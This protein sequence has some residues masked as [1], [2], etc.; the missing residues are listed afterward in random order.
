MLFEGRL[1][2]C[3]WVMKGL[4]LCWLEN[5]YS[6]QCVWAAFISHATRE[7]QSPFF[8]IEIQPPKRLTKLKEKSIDSKMCCTT[9]KADCAVSNLGGVIVPFVTSQKYDLGPTA[10]FV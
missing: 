5:I 2:R 1:H 3:G 4:A 6:A 8:I 7:T 10:Y 9:Q